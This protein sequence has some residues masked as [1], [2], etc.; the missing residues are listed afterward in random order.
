MH[1]D[2]LGCQNE[3]NRWEITGGLERQ[4]ALKNRY[5]EDQDLVTRWGWKFISVAVAAGCLEDD[6]YTK[7]CVAEL[8]DEERDDHI[9][10]RSVP[11]H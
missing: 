11:K 7:A 10:R 8:T 3:M 5:T 1:T 4:D 9:V 6:E 2:L